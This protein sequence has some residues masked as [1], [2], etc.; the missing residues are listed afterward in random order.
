MDEKFKSIRV[1]LPTYGYL[2][3]HR[4]LGLKS[5]DSVIWDMIEDR[6]KAEAKIKEL[7]AVIKGMQE[8][9]DKRTR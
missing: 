3:D 1:S 7:E 6:T 4:T 2:M 8:T 5:M 9:E